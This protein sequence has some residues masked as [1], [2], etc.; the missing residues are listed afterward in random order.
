MP[1]EW[2]FARNGERSGPVGFDELKRRASTGLLWADDLVWG[3][4]EP[5]WKPASRIVGLFPRIATQWYY[6]RGGERFGPVPEE[7]LEQLAVTSRLQEFDLVW[8]EAEPDWKPALQIPILFK[9]FQAGERPT[10]PEGMI[11]R[12]REDAAPEEMGAMSER[13]RQAVSFIG[14]G[15]ST[16]VEPGSVAQDPPGRSSTSSVAARFLCWPSWSRPRSCPSRSVQPSG[17]MCRRSRGASSGL[18]SVLFWLGLAALWFG[19]S[20]ALIVDI[21]GAARTQGWPRNVAPLLGRLG[22]MGALAAI[23]CMV[24]WVIVSNLTGLSGAGLASLALLILASTVGL[25]LGC[26]VVAMAPRPQEAW[27]ASGLVMVLLSL[28]GGGRQSFPRE[29]SWARV[30][31]NAVPSRWAFEGLLLLRADRPT[32]PETVRQPDQHRR[33]DIAEAYFP[34]DSERMGT[35][36]EV[37]ALVSTLIGL[38]AT[39]AFL[40]WDSEERGCWTPGRG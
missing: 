7:V 24:A 26:I 19:L 8:S 17:P 13:R 37:M 22:V 3:E 14:A 38:S 40:T 21:L 2:Y 12:A 11:R 35:R 9:V 16:S 15:D 4:G 36:A 20:D 27:A 1:T 29:A 10:R 5:D 33:W 28:F 23:Q 31:S 18:A 30:T 34:A 39:S 25:A 6:S 32:L